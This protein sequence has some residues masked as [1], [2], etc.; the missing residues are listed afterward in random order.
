MLCWTSLAT[1]SVVTM[2]MIR[3]PATTTASS[4]LASGARPTSDEA[5]SSGPAV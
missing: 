2:P 3:P 5:G 4:A 1:S